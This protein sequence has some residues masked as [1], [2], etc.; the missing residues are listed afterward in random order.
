MIKKA[1]SS[2]K[3]PELQPSDFGPHWNTNYYEIIQDYYWEPQHIDRAKR[4]HPKYGNDK[5]V[6]WHIHQMEVSLNHLLALFF[7][8]TPRDFI[9]RLECSAFG[10]HSSADFRQVSLFELR[11]TYRHDPTQ[12]DVF[13]VAADRCLSIEVKIDAKSSLEQVAKYALLHLDFAKRNGIPTDGSRLIYLT[14]RPVSQTWKEKFLGVSAM[15]SALTAFDFAALLAKAKVSSAITAEELRAVALAMPVA[16][17]SFT[18]FYRLTAEYA[19]T[20]PS[21]AKPATDTV[22]KLF[23]GLLHELRFRHSMLKLSI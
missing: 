13:L 14:P 17:L 5:Q 16:H 12:P 11:A 21:D 10:S 9:H 6:L 22:A 2:L 4:E 8:L 3:P 18:D 19:A 20:I 7:S 1:E 15:R 23:D